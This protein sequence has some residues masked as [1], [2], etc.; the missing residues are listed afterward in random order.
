[1]KCCVVRVCKEL[2]AQSNAVYCITY[3]V[4]PPRRQGYARQLLLAAVQLAKE[5]QLTRLQ[6]DVYRSNAAA[7][8]LYRSNGFV[9]QSDSIVRGLFSAMKMGKMIMIKTL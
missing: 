8:A 2:N 6:L 7:V 5:E 3:R 9:E 1:V 4:L